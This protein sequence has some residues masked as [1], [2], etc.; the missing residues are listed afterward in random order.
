MLFEGC[1][2]KSKDISLEIKICPQC[3]AEVEVFS[4]DTEVPCENCGFVVYNDALSCMQWCQYAQQ[5]VG[6]ETYEKMMRVVDHRKEQQETERLA[7]K[8]SKHD[9]VNG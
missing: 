1:Q 9:Q 2:S 6:N 7:S 5:C 3:G 8:S 4:V